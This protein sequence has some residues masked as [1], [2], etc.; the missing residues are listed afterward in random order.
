[1][2]N[3]LPHP[4]PTLIPGS[5][6]EQGGRLCS[7]HTKLNSS[8]AALAEQTPPCPAQKG[9][10]GSSSC[11]WGWEG[12]LTPHPP[13]RRALDWQATQWT[14]PKGDSLLSRGLCGPP[15][16]P[17]FTLG[18]VIVS[19]NQPP[20]GGCSCLTTQGYYPTTS[21]IHAPSSKCSGRLG[22]QPRKEALPFQP[23]CGMNREGGRGAAAS[24]EE[25]DPAP[26]QGDQPGSASP[27]CRRLPS[28]VLAQ[29]QAAPLTHPQRWATHSH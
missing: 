14:Q 4:G 6:E 7:A 25:G 21:V 18:V 3:W 2:R 28:R 16:P 11:P 5:W 15:A 10:A 1:M 26:G 12:G 20:G 13:G 23:A 24:R 29:S 22:R 8:F 19:S 9:M 17:A 27:R